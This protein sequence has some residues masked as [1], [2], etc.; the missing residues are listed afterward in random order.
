MKINISFSVD[1]QNDKCIVDWLTTQRN[2]SASIRKSIYTQMKYEQNPIDANLPDQL[3][4]IGIA[5]REIR[6]ML[7][8]RPGQP[9]P[10]TGKEDMP[11]DVIDNILKLG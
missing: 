11:K 8:N 4:Q 6:A 5:L 1:P 7:E 3:N 9:I 10:V 2:K